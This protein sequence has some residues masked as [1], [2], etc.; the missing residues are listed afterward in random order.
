MSSLSSVIKSTQY[1]GIHN[2]ILLP[3]DSPELRAQKKRAAEEK[4]AEKSTEKNTLDQTINEA[5]EQSKLILS[6]AFNKAKQIMEAAQT[7]SQSQI[8]EASE[9]M[10][11]ECVQMK[12][13]SHDEGYALGMLEGRNAGKTAGYR[14]GYEEGLQKAAS[15]DQQKA[16]E[17]SLMLETV[18]KK[19]AQILEK[20]SGELEELAIIIVKKIIKKELSMD[21]D[22]MRSIIVNAIDSYRNQD[23]VRICVSKDTADILLKADNSIIDALK[24]V[25]D[26]VKVVVSPDMS[27]TDCII[28]MPEQLIDA[29]IDT[30]LENIQKAL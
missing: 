6:N 19:K 11:L 3:T 27:N 16:D 15:E 10:N 12:R 7:Y 5:Q 29:G 21:E 2:V 8:K 4:S 20:F 24:N 17:L 9:R 28:D 30:Q 22:V 13:Q 1:D 25:S 23:W 14:E 18:E 26:S